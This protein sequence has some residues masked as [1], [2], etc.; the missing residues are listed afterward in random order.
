MKSWLEKLLPEGL[1]TRKARLK[2]YGNSR[3]ITTATYRVVHI[4]GGWPVG[5]RLLTSR[6]EHLQLNPARAR[7]KA[8]HLSANRKAG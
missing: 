8:S 2:D 4:S 3:I 7:E 5:F 6:A 1:C